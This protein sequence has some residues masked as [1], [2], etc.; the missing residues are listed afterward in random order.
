MRSA[1]TTF[2]SKILGPQ[3]LPLAGLVFAIRFYADGSSEELA[4]DEPI[5]DQDGWLWLH[6]NLADN[7]AC[8]FL[9]S[10]SCLTAPARESLTTADEHQKLHADQ[11]C[12]HGIL[13]DLVCGLGGAT[14]EIG[15]LHFALTETLLVSSRRHTLNAVESTRRALRGGLRVTTTAALLEV[16]IENV[17]EAV[18]RYAGGLAD[19]L[20]RIEERI[21]ADE[22]SIDRQMIGRIRRMTVRLHRQL[23]IL[24]S[25]ILRFEHEL[26]PLL[27]PILRLATEKLHQRLEWL[28]TE[29]IA[30]RD[31]SH[32]LQEEI[33]L[34][35]AEQTNRNLQVL[36]FVT[37]VFLPAS[38]I[39]GIFG[40]NV[41]GLPLTG[42]SSG[43]VS[44][45]S[46]ICKSETLLVPYKATNGSVHGADSHKL[47]PSVPG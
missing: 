37:T 41:G 11:S 38:L 40:M 25:L 16:I 9:S 2:S 5:A 17:V 27:K 22:V 7:R 20:D 8:Q 1:T 14:E 13:A 46:L 39:A 18:D 45:R 33:T 24:R 47:C 10:A 29:I 4:V 23:V 36:A 6:F 43:F 3:T 31:R 12:V 21:L 15:F 44:V 42:D 34:K 26:E 30:L 19:H 28:D 35:T 32:L